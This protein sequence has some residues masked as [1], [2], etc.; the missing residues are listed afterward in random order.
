MIERDLPTEP[1]TDEDW[2]AG[3][4]E[5]EEAREQWPDASCSPRGYTRPERRSFI[6]EIFV[7]PDGKLWVEVIRNAGNRWEFFDTE[8]RLLGSVPTVPHKERT[9][10][11]FYADHLVTIR[12]DDLDLDHVDVWR[13]ERVG[14]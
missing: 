7:A 14:R 8:G 6:E 10:P 5:F 11:V 3:S 9:V 1:I 4:A 13:L 12:Q 2:A